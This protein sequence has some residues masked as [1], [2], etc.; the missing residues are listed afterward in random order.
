MIN[1]KTDTRAIA[2]MLRLKDDSLVIAAITTGLANFDYR[3]FKEAHSAY[4]H[5]DNK[6]NT[7]VKMTALKRWI[8][9]CTNRT[10][11]VIAYNESPPF[12]QLKAAALRKWLELSTEPIHASSAFD[13]SVEDGGDMN[14]CLARWDELTLD[15]FGRAERIDQLEKVFWEA[16][17]LSPVRVMAIQ[18]IAEKLG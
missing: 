17:S 6:L 4:Y 7:E 14:A 2:G 9:L 11:A 5:A 12:S 1:T 3:S 18:K 8:E 16:S 10:D 15:A 13:R